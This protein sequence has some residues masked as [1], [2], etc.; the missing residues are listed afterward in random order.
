MIHPLDRFGAWWLRRGRGPAVFPDGWGNPDAVALLDVARHPISP[1]PPATIEWGRRWEVDGLVVEDGSFPTPADLP[2]AAHRVLVRRVAPAGGTRRS[3][4]VMPAWNDEGFR[5]RTPFAVAL[6]RRGIGAFLLECPF[7][8][9]RRV[10]ADG[11][12]IRSVAEFALMGRAVVA[13]ALALVA[14][15]ADHG[16]VGVTGY[17]MGGNLAAFVGALSPV[18]IAVAP[19]AASHSPGPVFC[20][21]A[22]RAGI[23][24][25]VFGGADAEPRLAVALGSVSV[26]SLPPT[27]STATAVLVA[28]RRDG[29]V[30]P[31]ATVELHRHWPGSELRWCPGGHGTSWWFR[32]R[33]LVDAVADAFAR[34]EAVAPPPRP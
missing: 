10:H 4:L 5:G 14:A 34:V 15:T 27:P 32:R 28:A 20:G 16:T 24:W 6:A 8:G 12:G 29:F 9:S 26:L 22:L 30:P 21:G 25:D 33:T 19:L 2:R 1:P 17:S 13:E 18:D 31:T 11:P 23:R 7:Y 3:C